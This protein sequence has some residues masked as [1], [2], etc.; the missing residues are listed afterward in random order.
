M[1]D[2]ITLSIP[3]TKMDIGNL[4]QFSPSAINVPVEVVTANTVLGLT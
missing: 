4:E 2:T 1:I 3:V